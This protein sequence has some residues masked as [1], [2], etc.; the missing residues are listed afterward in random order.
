MMTYGISSYLNYSMYSAC[1]VP[2]VFSAP[3]RGILGAIWF[4]T[5]AVSITAC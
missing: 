1:L 5:M 2:A 3:A 4:L